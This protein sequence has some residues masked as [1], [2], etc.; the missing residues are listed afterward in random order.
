MQAY[1]LLKLAKNVCY[2][3]QEITD[4]QEAVRMRDAHLA[5][6]SRQAD[7]DQQQIDDLERQLLMQVSLA[8]YK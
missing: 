6:C 3:V 4:L 1:A 5:E 8:I 7:S 2:T